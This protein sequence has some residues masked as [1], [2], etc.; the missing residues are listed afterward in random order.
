MTKCRHGFV[1]SDMNVLRKRQAGETNGMQ[2]EQRWLLFYLP[3]VVAINGSGARQTS[4]HILCTKGGTSMNLFQTC[5]GHWHKKMHRV[6]GCK[7]A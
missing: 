3:F 6:W 1:R 4:Q 7:H 2:E 5:Q